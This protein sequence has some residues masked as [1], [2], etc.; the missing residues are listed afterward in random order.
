MPDNSKKPDASQDSK[1]DTHPS[2]NHERAPEA[3]A[4]DTPMDEMSDQE[5]IDAL[6]KELSEKEGASDTD[7]DR[8]KDPK[9]KRV[10]A[11][12]KALMDQAKKDPERKEKNAQ[13]PKQGPRKSRILMIQL[14]GAFHGNFTINLILLY[15]VN[16]VLILGLLEGLNF[17]QFPR[18][19]WMPITFVLIYTTCEVLFKEFMVARFTKVILMTFGF[20]FYFGYVIL[21][22]LVDALIFFNVQIFAGEAELAVFTLLFMLSRQLMSIL[23]KKGLAL[24]L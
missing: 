2:Q 22:Y 19:L 3:S 5:K 18:E 17:G 12:I 16:L 10:A 1:K 21:F 11:Q 20:I 6:I 4:S 8:Q 9:T 7:E 14:G 23:I 13:S 24:K 15:L